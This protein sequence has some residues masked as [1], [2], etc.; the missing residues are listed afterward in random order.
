MDDRSAD[1]RQDRQYQIVRLRLTWSKTGSFEFLGCSGKAIA[2]YKSCVRED[3]GV[4]KVRRGMMKMGRARWIRVIGGEENTRRM[5]MHGVKGDELC[6]RHATQAARHGHS[7]L[8]QVVG[9]VSQALISGFRL[10]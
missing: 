7:H 9:S 8:R 6:T 3:L 4:V 1:A 5:G 2:G 10:T